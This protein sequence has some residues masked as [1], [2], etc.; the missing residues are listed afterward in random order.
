MHKAVGSRQWAVGERLAGGRLSSVV[1]RPSSVVGGPS[2]SDSSDDLLQHLLNHA[3][4]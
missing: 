2:C 4:E 1:C 3:H